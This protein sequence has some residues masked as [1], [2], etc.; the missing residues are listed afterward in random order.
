MGIASDFSIRGIDKVMKLVQ[1]NTHKPLLAIRA[2]DLGHNFGERL[3]KVK[4]L[5]FSR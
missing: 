4:I 3:G 5:G 1:G 2:P